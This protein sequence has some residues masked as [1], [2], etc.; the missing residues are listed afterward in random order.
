[1]FFLFT[2][3]GKQRPKTRSWWRGKATINKQNNVSFLIGN[4]WKAYMTPMGWDI[5]K[6]DCRPYYAFLKICYLLLLIYYICIWIQLNKS[7]SLAWSWMIFHLITLAE[8]WNHVYAHCTW[9]TTKPVFDWKFLKVKISKHSQP[10]RL[11]TSTY[12]VSTHGVNDLY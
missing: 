1:M 6:F 7:I 2:V 12:K 5:L 10:V 11:N 3:M 9:W 4:W 8:T